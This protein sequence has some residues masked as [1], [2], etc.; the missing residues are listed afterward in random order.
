MTQIEKIKENIDSNK[1]ISKR[2]KNESYYNQDQFI[3]DAKRYIKA[4]KEGR[5]ICSID[6]VSA[7]G[8]SR[9]IKFLSCEKRSIDKSYIYLNYFAFFCTLAFSPADKNSHYFR[10]SG[11]GMDMIF[12]TNYTII[13]TLC[14]LGFINKEQ[15]RYLAQQ[16]PG[17]I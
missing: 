6:K 12:H 15:C 8:M 3:N 11:C 1:E 7:S 4:L 5:M 14:D 16:T 9:T 17:V 13:H 2:L 10:I